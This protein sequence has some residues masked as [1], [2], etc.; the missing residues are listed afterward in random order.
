ME[1]FFAGTLVGIVATSVWNAFMR[2]P[3]PDA[4]QSPPPQLPPMR[5]KR[6]S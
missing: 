5:K 3:P 4:P 1:L 2:P 6:R